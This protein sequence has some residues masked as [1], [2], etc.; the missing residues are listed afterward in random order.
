MHQLLSCINSNGES[1]IS[2]INNKNNTFLR[3]T[4]AIM[5]TLLSL[6]SLSVLSLSVLSIP[7]ESLIAPLDRRI[8]GGVK[9]GKT[10]DDVPLSKTEIKCTSRSQDDRLL[11]AYELLIAKAIIQK[12]T[13]VHPS[14]RYYQAMFSRN[15]K[16]TPGFEVHVHQKYTNL[17][18][19]YAENDK[20]VTI[21]CDVSRCKPNQFATTLAAENNINLCPPWFDDAQKARTSTVASDCQLSSSKGHNWK[22]LDKYKATKC[23]EPVHML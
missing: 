11:I 23:E 19:I 1:S 18:S 8:I 7:H 21:T 6:L 22:S 14:S 12:G 15:R 20:K 5:H 10:H 2:E 17:A 4:I 9:T 16:D 13:T 3:A